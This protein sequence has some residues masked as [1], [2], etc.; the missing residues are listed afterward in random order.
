MS[1]SLCTLHQSAAAAHDVLISYYQHCHVPCRAAAG[2]EAGAAFL[3]LDL[4]RVE[5]CQEA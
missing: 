5:A 3:W 2:G 4:Q 1:E